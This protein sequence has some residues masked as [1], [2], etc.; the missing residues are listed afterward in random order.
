MCINTVMH[1]EHINSLECLF[2]HVHAFCMKWK[3]S[4]FLTCLEDFNIPTVKSFS[5]HIG[6]FFFSSQTQ[7]PLLKGIK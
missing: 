2:N 1:L 4:K 7:W 3:N 5:P 6:N